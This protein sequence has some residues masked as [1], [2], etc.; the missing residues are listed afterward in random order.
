MNYSQAVRKE[1]N[2]LITLAHNVGYSHA[3]DG[4][5]SKGCRE[6]SD[7]LLTQYTKKFDSLLTKATEEARRD[8]QEFLTELVVAMDSADSCEDSCKAVAKIL[9][10][11]MHPGKKLVP[12]KHKSPALQ[13]GEHDKA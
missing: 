12:A 3:N 11:K 13:E 7:G 5:D 4:L 10:E 8:E 2:D 9:G 6:R 1:V